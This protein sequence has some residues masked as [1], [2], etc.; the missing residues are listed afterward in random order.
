MP[1][2]KTRSL[3]ETEANLVWISHTCSVIDRNYPSIWAEL[4]ESSQ[5]RRLWQQEVEVEII[6]KPTD[7]SLLQE[8][9]SWIK[10]HPHPNLKCSLA[11]SYCDVKLRTR[12]VKEFKSE[13]KNGLLM[14]HVYDSHVS[15]ESLLFQL[16][17]ASSSELIAVSSPRIWGSQAGLQSQIRMFAKSRADYLKYQGTLLRLRNSCF[18]MAANSLLM[19][20]YKDE[21]S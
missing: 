17:A 5:H 1:V 18:D 13:I 11:L 8:R 15:T 9:I 6:L 21:E 7:V 4:W 2:I 14:M 16:L 20:E 12:L 3:K 19:T 10:Q